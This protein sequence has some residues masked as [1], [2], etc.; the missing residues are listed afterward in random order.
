[1][2]LTLI[3]D[4]HGQHR[5]LSLSKGETL[6]H[7]GDISK[8]GGQAEVKDFLQWFSEQDY[9]HRIFIAGNHDFYFE[10]A[11]RESVSNIIPEGVT[12]LND[13]GVEIGGIRF[14]GSPVQPRFYD[15]A[16]N[17][18]RGRDIQKHWDLIPA[19]TDVLITHGPPSFILDKTTGGMNAGCENLM[20][21]LAQLR[22]KLHVFGHIHEAYGVVDKHHRTYVNASVL[23]ENYNLV[24]APVIYPL[25]L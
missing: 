3:S 20:G 5:S 16:F 14:W 8:R 18:D 21:T 2:Q 24:N 9:E 10:E 1:M 11:S 23:N 17:R 22:V 6:I 25:E 4:T 19:D 7:A 13:S 15:W 12:Y